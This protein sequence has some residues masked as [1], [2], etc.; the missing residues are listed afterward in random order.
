MSATHNNGTGKEV[1]L[2]ALLAWV[3]LQP[4]EAANYIYRLQQSAKS[5]DTMLFG[6]RELFVAVIKVV[7]DA[8]II[9]SEHQNSG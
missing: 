9:E 3:T 7:D 5:Y 2:A 4:D 1:N 8:R 6:F